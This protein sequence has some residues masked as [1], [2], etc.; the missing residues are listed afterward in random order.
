M[1]GVKLTQ[2]NVQ[3]NKDEV[4]APLLRKLRLRVVTSATQEPRVCRLVF[5]FL[6]VELYKFHPTHWLYS[7]GSCGGRVSLM[8]LRIGMNTHYTLAYINYA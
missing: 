7:F 5:A 4:M 1:C 3:K 2:Y 6:H 8:R